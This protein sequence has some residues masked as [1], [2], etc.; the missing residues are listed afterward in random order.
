MSY[1]FYKAMHLVGI[2]MTFLSIGAYFIGGHSVGKKFLGKRLAGTT[3][4]LGLALALV[5]GFGL[6]ARL[7]LTSPIPGW[8]YGKFL[9]WVFLGGIITLAVRKPRWFNSLWALA[10]VAG[11]VAAYLALY[12]PF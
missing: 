5:G 4:G 1:Q 10:I 6:I 11:I 9:I 12:K 7:G 2:L 8:I 3:H